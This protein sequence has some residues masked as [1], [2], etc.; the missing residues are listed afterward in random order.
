MVFFFIALFL[1]GTVAILEYF[2]GQKRHYTNYL[3][4]FLIVWAA[5]YAG[6]IYG[7]EDFNPYHL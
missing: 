3:T 1:V 6:S 4:W 2:T 5:L 7:G